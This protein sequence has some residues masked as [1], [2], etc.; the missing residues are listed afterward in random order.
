MGVSTTAD[1]KRDEALEHVRQ[2][3]RCLSEIVIEQCYGHDD[4]GAEYRGT[5][6]RT[7]LELLEI[8]DRL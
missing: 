6:Q 5:L 3:I 8:R 1:E 2:A 7:L 4:W